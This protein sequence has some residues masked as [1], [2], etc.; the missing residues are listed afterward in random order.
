MLHS[1]CLLLGPLQG[2][3]LIL[4]LGYAVTIACL[5]LV[6]SY[7]LAL[8][9]VLDTGQADQRLL[10]PGAATSAAG[11]LVGSLRCV[12]WSAAEAVQRLCSSA[13]H[14]VITQAVCSDA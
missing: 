12:W 1:Q 10:A 2:G 11:P 9:P 14:M 6:V 4:H 5:V 3:Y 13:R 8:K 7:L